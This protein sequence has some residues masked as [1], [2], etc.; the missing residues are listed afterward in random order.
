MLKIILKILF[1]ISLLILVIWNIESKNVLE[2]LRKISLW[3]IF[4]SLTCLVVQSLLVS[5]R[6][7]IILNSC[8]KEVPY[9]DVLRMHYISL[10]TSLF[11]PSVIAEPA[12]KSILMKKYHVTISKSLLS[13]I[14][15][16]LFVLAGLFIMTV[17]VMP[18]IMSRYQPSN[19]FIMSYL[20]FIVVLTTSY[21]LQKIKKKIKF[22]VLLGR[23][24]T[25]Y[26]FLTDVFRY[27]ICDSKLISKCVLLTIIGQ[28]SS[29]TAFYYLAIKLDVNISYS[30]CLLLITPALL[31]TTIP[32]AFN[33]WG[34]RE[35][36]II[37]MLG[38]VN[39]SSQT[40]LVL[41]IQYGMIGLLLWSIGLLSWA[42]YRFN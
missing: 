19:E 4:I 10:G 9:K 22:E 29:I 39:I 13:V 2:N 1:S 14:L 20:F 3:T 35:L 23:Y 7:K 37:Y 8:C 28:I 17:F 40:A 41:S 25:N 12:L 21:L 33:G 36:S 18:V 11:L 32:I 34:V 6:W 31:I 30:E 27:L 42:I 5:W 16:K 38:I 24:L 26:Y 15:D